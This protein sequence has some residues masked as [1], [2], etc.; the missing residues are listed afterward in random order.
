VNTKRRSIDLGREVEVHVRRVPPELLQHL[1]DQ[2]LTSGQTP[3]FDPWPNTADESPANM[4]SYSTSSLTA[5]Q[6]PPVAV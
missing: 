1:F 2:C 5:G 6:I 3:R 4:T